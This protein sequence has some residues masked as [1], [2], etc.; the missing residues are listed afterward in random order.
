MNT[1]YHYIITTFTS[2]ENMSDIDIV[3]ASIVM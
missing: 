3:V 2:Q 1:N